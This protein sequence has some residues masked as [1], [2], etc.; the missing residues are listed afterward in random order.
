[1]GSL[2]NISRDTIT[3]NAINKENIMPP[4]TKEAYAGTLFNPTTVNPATGT[5]SD[6]GLL[7]PA[8]TRNLTG[9]PANKNTMGKAKTLKAKKTTLKKAKKGK[10]KKTKTKT[11]SR[12][13]KTL[14]S[15]KRKTSGRKTAKARGRSKSKPKKARRR[16]TN[17]I[18]LLSI[19]R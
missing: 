1:M 18:K 5:P 16:T 2:W 7:A 14:K 15:K 17:A 3:A 8:Q 9:A 4:G 10:T 6:T 12:K 11:A 19:L 13:I